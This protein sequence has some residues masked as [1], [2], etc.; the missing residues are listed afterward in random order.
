MLINTRLN[1]HVDDPGLEAVTAVGILRLEGNCP[2]CNAL[3]HNTSYTRTGIADGITIFHWTTAMY[4]TEMCRDTVL[5]SRYAIQ[6][7]RHVQRPC[8]RLDL[9]LTFTKVGAHEHVMHRGI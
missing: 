2:C 1:I 7:M 5:R 4:I 9:T 6:I 8:V 3:V